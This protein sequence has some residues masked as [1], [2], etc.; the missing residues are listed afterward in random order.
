MAKNGFKAMDFDMHVI[1]PVDLWQLYIDP[2]YA[3]R[4]SVGFKRS[5]RDLGI[6]VEGKVLPI[7]RNPE[8]PV[9]AKYCNAFFHDK[10]GEVGERHFD[11]VSQVMV[12]DEENLNI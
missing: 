12:M 11:G 1:E 3:D 8:N 9:L 2:K 5:F 10:Y 4:A 6:E 7:P